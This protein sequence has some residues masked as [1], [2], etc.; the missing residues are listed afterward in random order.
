MEFYNKDIID[1]RPDHDYSRTLSQLGYTCRRLSHYNTPRIS[2]MFSFY[3]I[4]WL[5]YL[6]F[7]SQRIVAIYYNYIVAIYTITINIAREKRQRL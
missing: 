4:A 3:I 6:H 7:K 5:K 2:P 1:R